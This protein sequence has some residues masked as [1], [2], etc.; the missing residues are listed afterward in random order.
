MFWLKA[1][2]RCGGDLY[3]VN[4]LG[5]RYVKC[6]QCGREVYNLAE[7]TVEPTIVRQRAETKRRVTAA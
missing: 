5:E 7:I 3:E 4:G 2:K 6:L 1:C